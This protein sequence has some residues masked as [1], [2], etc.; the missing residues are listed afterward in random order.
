MAPVIPSK[1]YILVAKFL[2]V[3]PVKEG[4]QLVINH[5]EY[6]VIV[7]TVALV[8]KSGFIWCKGE[9]TASVKVEQIGPVG[10]QQVVGRIVKIF[11]PELNYS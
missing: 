11:K 8:D 3:F 2:L 7:K 9:N 10:K 1:S 6:G 4:Q 5:P